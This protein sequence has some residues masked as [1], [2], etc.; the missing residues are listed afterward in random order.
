M[1][2]F[3]VEVSYEG[4]DNEIVIV[5]PRGYIDSTTCTGLEKIILEQ[6]TKKRYKIIVHLDEC[7]YVNSSGW[8]VFIREIKEIRK[9]EGDLV[10]VN[11]QPD[12]Y[13]VYETMEFSK[14]LKSFES[15]QEGIAYF[16]SDSD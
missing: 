12:V 11:M 4:N 6:I 2:G 10:L 14:I 8:G 16:C 9:N 15:L 5:Q 7:E 1:D 3:R 13:M